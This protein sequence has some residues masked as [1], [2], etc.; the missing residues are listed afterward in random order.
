MA[1]AR[2]IF[3]RWAARTYGAVAYLCGLALIFFASALTHTHAAGAAAVVLP[4]GAI[5]TLLAAPIFAVH[6]W[7]MLTAAASVVGFAIL[8]GIDDP[9]ARP[10]CAT[11]AGVFVLLTIVG[12]AF[13]S[14]VRAAGP[15]GTVITRLHA[16][17]VCLYGGFIAWIGPQAY[18]YHLGAPHVS[19]WVLAAGAIY[20]ALSVFVWR[21]HVWAMIAVFV[22]TF[23]QWVALASLDPTFWR[24][25]NFF[26]PP[27]VSAAL[28]LV[29][30]VGRR[31]A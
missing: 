11:V 6:R 20:G 23:V 24:D 13:G 27:I 17:A 31:A 19:S 15:G 26:V 14:H 2:T 3:G 10:V 25:A 8:I 21:G 30:V 9:S 22:L 16:A 12:V 29:C 5:L 4:P 1:E 18:T 28:T 7:A